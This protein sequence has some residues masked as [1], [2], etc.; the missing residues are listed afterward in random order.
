MADTN[1]KGAEAP[2]KEEEKKAEF[3]PTVPV[4]NGHPLD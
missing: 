2:K 1:E 3:P 4:N